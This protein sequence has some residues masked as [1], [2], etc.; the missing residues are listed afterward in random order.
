[1]SLSPLNRQFQQHDDVTDPENDGSGTSDDDTTTR[2]N[3][4]TE[5]DVVYIQLIADEQYSLGRGQSMETEMAHDVGTK[6]FVV[7]QPTDCWSPDQSH[8][9]KVVMG[10]QD[11]A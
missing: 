4:D 5:E 3:H 11:M 1:M 2:H 10:H 8:V 6:A 9:D 7:Y